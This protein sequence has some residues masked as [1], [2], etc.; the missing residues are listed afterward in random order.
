MAGDAFRK[1]MQGEDLVIPAAT[2]NAFIDNLRKPVQVGSRAISRVRPRPHLIRV[3]NL[4]GGDVERFGVLGI[5]G[6][7][8]DPD[9]NLAG[10][11]EAPAL[12][13]V[14]PADAHFG[15][16]VIASEPIAEGEIGLCY[17]SGICITKVYIPADG[18]FRF[19]DI[20]VGSLA[21]LTACDQG[22]AGI[23]WHENV[24]DDDAWAVISLS[25]AERRYVMFPISLDIHDTAHGD[26]T[27]PCGHTYDVYVL[28]TGALIGE[29]I[30]PTAIP[31]RYTRPEPGYLDIA[32]TGM[33]FRDEAYNLVIVWINENAPGEE[34]E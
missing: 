3:K 5:D 33:A 28:E 22:S 13:G 19:C 30:D 9:D 18:D 4:A 24:T 26:E 20:E 34:C 12:T 2:F 1:V 32:S 11:Q 16:F 10:F 23:L 25:P 6:P 15:R 7:L 27:T 31:H 21:R 17:A 29:D 8:I 14:T